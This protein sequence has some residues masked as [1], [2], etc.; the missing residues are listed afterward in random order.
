MIWEQLII[1]YNR[2]YIMTAGTSGDT[3]NLDIE[4][5]GLC[6]GHAYTIL[7]VL[8][9]ESKGKKIRLVHL[10]NP[11]GNGEYSGDWSDGD[12]KWTPSLKKK[13]G[14]KVEEKD[15]GQFYMSFDD[16]IYY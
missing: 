7:K 14:L 6:P 13:Y 10:R 1:G 4:E 5:V 11:W 12:S 16:F 8:E 2:G 9:L 3:T 15:D